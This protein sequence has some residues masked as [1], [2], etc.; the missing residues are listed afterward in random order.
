MRAAGRS[1]PARAS[2][3]G[4]PPPSRVAP[5]RGSRAFLDLPRAARRFDRIR[6]AQP[7][8]PAGARPIESI[9]LAAAAAYLADQKKAD[10][11]R[12]LELDGANRIADYVVLACGRS[13]PQVKA[14]YNE[15]HARLKAAGRTHSRAEGVELGWWVLL[16]F[17][18]VVVHVMQPEAREYYDLDALYAEAREIAWRE[19]ELP[20]LPLR[21]LRETGSDARDVT[22]E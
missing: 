8:R 10:D 5:R 1:G 14:I 7:D 17:G 6:A 15:L 21:R 18:D 11:V 16:D 19:V 4:H 13:R 12:V 3:E 22:A 2:P 20:A 9:A